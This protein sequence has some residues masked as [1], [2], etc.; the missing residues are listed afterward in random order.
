MQKNTVLTLGI[1]S[2]VFLGLA[3][4]HAGVKLVLDQ[5]T[6]L[7]MVGNTHYDLNN[8]TIEITLDR[9]V[10]C[11]KAAGYNVGS[12]TKLKVY[13]PN[14]E[15]K[16]GFGA[17][18]G[19]YFAS[20]ADYAVDNGQL[21]LETDNPAKAL[22]VSSELGSYDL[23]YKSPFESSAPYNARLKYVGLPNIVSPGQVLN[24][25]IELHNPSA[26]TIYFDLLEYWNEHF[27]HAAT[28]TAT[29]NQRSCNTGSAVQC[30]VIDPDTGV[31]KGIQVAAGGTFEL[32]V[33]QK[34]SET[35]AIGA[36]LDFMAA[37]FLTNGL[38]GDFLPRTIIEDPMPNDPHVA[39]LTATVANNSMPTVSWVTA[40][41]TVISFTEDETTPQVYTIKY[42]D[43]ETALQDLTVNVTDQLGNVVT[44]SLSNYVQNGLEATQ[45]LTI[46]PITNAYTNG[47]TPEQLTITVTDESAGVTTLLQDVEVIA[48]NDAP[49]FAMNCAELTI[50]EQNNEMTCTSPISNGGGNQIQGSWDDE[51]IIDNFNPGPNESHQTVQK[52]EVEVVDNSDGVLDTFGTGSAVT[53]DKNSGQVTVKNNNGVYGIA[54]VRVRVKDDGG[55]TGANGCDSNDPGY[56]ATEGCDVS[57]WQTLTIVSAPPVY[58]ISGTI[59]GLP[60]GSFVNMNLR[61]AG[62]GDAFVENE[63][64]VNVIGD[65]PLAFNFDYEA[66]NQ[67]N[68]KVV[69]DGQSNGYNC[70][71]ASASST[72]VD[73]DTITGTVNGGDV[74]DIIVTCTVIP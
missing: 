24:Y 48:V 26:Q 20:H 10:L 13:D 60:Q 17:N 41:P 73:P 70:D 16:G 47:G 15:M 33:T 8:N 54:E 30:P 56:V 22:C 44:A 59:T 32:S 51:F 64:K 1:L 68:Y 7:G 58:N 14:Q 49:T 61:D 28:I 57:E 36:E 62:N 6:P 72:Q 43:L 39:S 4:A 18:D 65:D 42:S 55:V 74:D 3:T 40:P 63:N 46:L 9:P 37:V 29:D 50:N 35:A 69:V 25:T 19:L 31:I 71:I 5:S 38:G 27:S 34:V 23:I 11:D 67:F 53:I 2:L 66:V 21:F 45:D 52:Y 12:L